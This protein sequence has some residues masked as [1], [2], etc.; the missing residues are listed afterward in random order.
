MNPLTYAEALQAAARKRFRGHT[1]L[2]GKAIPHYPH[3]AERAYKSLI[4]EYMEL[5]DGILKRHMPELKRV[6]EFYGGKRFDADEIPQQPDEIFALIESALQKKLTG[7]DAAAKLERIA[8]MT[9]KLSIE[10]WRR[11]CQTTL[12][13]DVLEDYYKGDFFKQAIGEWVQGNVD[14]ITTQP[15]DSLGKMRGL[16]REGFSEGRRPE[17]IAKDINASYAASKR[18]ARM[19]ARDQ[20][21]KLN[22]QI[23]QAQQRDA[24][25]SE[26]TWDTSRD[27]RVRPAHRKLHGKKFRWD[28]PPVVDEKTG[29]RCHPG[30]DYQ[31]RC[32]AIPV[33][34]IE[35]IAEIPVASVN[36][37]E[38]DGRI[39]AATS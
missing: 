2:K 22:A 18:H 33:F 28:D 4:G 23:T 29:R 24:G 32:E 21:A 19:I 12:G 26:Y 36:W 39:K 9:T 15:K 3:S 6:L 25:V 34:S 37:Q 8:A 5:Y 7:F 11:M 20:T 35:G 16:V 17:G 27:Q 30:E 13:I 31:C 14:L 38:V 10:D 1:T